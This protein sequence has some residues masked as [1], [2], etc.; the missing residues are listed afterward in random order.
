MSLSPTVLSVTPNGQPDTRPVPLIHT[1]LPGPRARAFL[2]RDQKYVSPSY[3]RVYPLV[4]ERGHGCV[5]EDHCLVGIN[6]VI[7]EGARIGR[8]SI[9]AGG[10]VVPEGR[11]F[12]PGSVIAGV[13]AKQIATRDS[14]RANRLN[15]WNYHRN[16]QFTRRG[17][18]RAWD[19]DEYREWLLSK[20]AEVEADRDL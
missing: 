18:Y 6:A 3:T 9:V 4:V 10:A 7:M 1:P 15:A 2:E 17:E 16:A 14:A 19:G 12:G 20:R 8:G 11:Q 5:I 13:P